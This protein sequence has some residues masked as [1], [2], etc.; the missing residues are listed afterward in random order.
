MRINISE[1]YREEFE[2]FISK[3][4]KLCD[5]IIDLVVDNVP[6]DELNAYC[7]RRYPDVMLRLTGAVSSSYIMRGIVE[8]CS[9]VYI[10]P[11]KGVIDHYYITAG[12]K[13]IEDYQC[14]LDETLSKLRVRYL[15]GSSKDIFNAQEI[16]FILDWMCDAASFPN[17]KRLLHKAFIHHLN[18]RII[19]QAT[20]K[21]IL[22]LFIYC[23]TFHCCMSHAIATSIQ[24]FVSSFA[25][26]HAHTHTHTSISA[27][28]IISLLLYGV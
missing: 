12:E 13:M 1:A 22:H 25:H 18:K 11:L 21:K 4:Q 15:L 3:Y 19:V 27:C 14:L 23:N 20:G 5:R 9:I 17:Y 6:I 2:V 8:K 28:V 16:I 24:L 10:I 7:R 26:M